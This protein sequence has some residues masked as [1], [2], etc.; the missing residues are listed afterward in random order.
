MQANIAAVL[1]E[2]KTE[3]DAIDAEALLA[4]VL[5]KE[6]GYFRA[7]PEREIDAKQLSEFRQL[8][9]R[10]AGGE[11]LAYLTGRREFLSLLLQVSPATLIPRPDTELLVEQALAI[12]PRDADWHVADLGTGSGAIALAIASERP[13]CHLIAT[14]ICADALD[15]ARANARRLNIGNVEFRRGDWHE[16]LQTDERF[17]LIAS[18]PPYVAAN[19]QHLRDDGLPFEPQHALTPGADGLAAIL[20]IIEEMKP[21]L[22]PLGRLLLEHGYDQ[23]AAVRALL[24][25]HGFEKITT[26]RDLGN[27]ERMTLARRPAQ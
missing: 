26:K 27:N 16:A 15:I 22:C 11:P 20:V 23:G 1:A 6:R 21:H 24:N 18:N 12:I 5:D 4:H 8:V 13:R 17:Q 25:R 7:W 10:R 3:I 2:A 9:T 19:D 14:D